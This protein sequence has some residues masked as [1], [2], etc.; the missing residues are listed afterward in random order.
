MTTDERMQE[1]YVVVTLPISTGESYIGELIDRGYKVISLIP[2]ADV[3]NIEGIFEGLKAYLGGRSVVIMGPERSEELADCVRDYNVV[4]VVAGSEAGVRCADELAAQLGLD[5]NSPETTWLR[6]NK[7]GMT[8]ALEKAGLRHIRTVKVGCRQDIVDFWNMNGCESVVMKFAESGATV[9]VQVCDS[10]EYAL[11]YYEQMKTM[12]NFIGI[13]GG[14]ILIQEYIGGDEYVVDTTSCDGKHKVCALWVYRKFIR[15]SNILY[16]AQ[17][18]LGKVTPVLREIIDYALEVLDAVDQRFGACHIEIKYDS[19][20]PV[21]I[22]TNPRPH[23]DSLRRG[24][25]RDAI[26]NCL[27]DTSLDSLIDKD[28]FFGRPDIF[29]SKQSACSLIINNLSPGSISLAPLL[30][31]FSHRSGYHYSTPDRRDVWEPPESKDLQSCVNSSK[32]TGPE[33]QL[34]ALYQKVH[35]INMDYPDLLLSFRELGGCGDFD[36]PVYSGTAAVYDDRLRPLEGQSDM[37]DNVI[38]AA[39]SKGTITDR[40][41]TMFEIMR[42]IRKG[43]RLLVPR[44]MCDTMPYGKDGLRRIFDLFDMPVSDLGDGGI[45]AVIESDSLVL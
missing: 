27:V 14:D 4:A 7:E 26:D 44:A 18:L 12:P 37:Y 20:G 1:E 19:R 9:G 15:G 16:G 11:E 23:G 17:L 30:T 6:N 22:E 42:H 13:V 33:E 3:E 24:F 45:S 10:L 43:G 39:K 36:M 34:E 41:E 28:A 35:V 32:F 40:Y 31:L 25:L 21:L 38:L 29:I 5:G 8:R 2:Y